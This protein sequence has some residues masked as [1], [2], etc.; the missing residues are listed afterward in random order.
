MIQGTRANR[1]R[2][3]EMQKKFK[4]LDSDVPMKNE[5]VDGRSE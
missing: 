5:V 3:K 2:L 1:K 4:L